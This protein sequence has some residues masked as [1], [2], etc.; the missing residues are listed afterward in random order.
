M[1][2]ACNIGFTDGTHLP[3]DGYDKIKFYNEVPELEE[4]YTG[5]N[6]Q[7]KEDVY[8]RVLNNLRTYPFVGIKRE[9]NSD[10]LEFAGKVYAFKNYHNDGE[11]IIEENDTLYLQ[12]SA[13]TTIAVYEQWNKESESEDER[14]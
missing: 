8:Y 3:L 4:Y 1:D 12:T 14:W 7:Q 11:V 6:L 10:R 5:Y 13:I 2:I 9:Y